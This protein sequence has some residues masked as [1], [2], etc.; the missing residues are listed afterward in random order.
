M[1]FT[2]KIDRA[3]QWAGEKMGAETKTSQSD[4]FQMLEG[5]M[6]FRQTGM[7]SLQKSAAIYVKWAARR[8]DASE[9]KGRST[10]MALL[11]R[12]MTAHSNDF[13]P[14]SEFGNC[15]AHVGRTNERVADF[16]SSYVEDVTA[17]WLQHLERSVTM[18]K[19]YQ[20]ARKKL[21]SRRL[22]YDASLTK[23]QKA[24]RDDFRVEEE[25][26]V[27]KTKYDDSSE[28]V[29]RRMQ[30]IKDA[31]G[32]N[33]GAL[34][35]L[36]DA[37]LA[38]HE[39]AVDE[40]RRARQTL[41]DVSP[42]GSTPQD[43]LCVPRARPSAARSCQPSLQQAR[44]PDYEDMPMPE[45]VTSRRLA[46]AQALPPPPSLQ[47]RPSMMRAS[48]YG[49]RSASAAVTAR[50]PAAR[51]TMDMAYG[52]RED[53]YSDESAGSD[54]A[55][56]DWGTRSISSATSHDSLARVSSVP[57]AKKARPPP[58]VNRAKKPPPP[59]V[60]ARRANLGY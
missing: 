25:M 55:S 6:G 41:A 32:E 36:L 56:P 15:L 29:L 20:A 27:C 12:S 28:D 60:P 52:S 3:R 23:M 47:A 30:D 22:A 11:G 39:R 13:E 5:E 31:E 53:A 35:S 7:E 19:E 50:A 16:H 44:S 51:N 33:V 42:L 8:C 24:K 10:P 48:T 37:E 14:G 18:M 26:R 49:A 46:G 21:E 34:S 43:E 59:L 1:T 45:R 54:G 40:L 17:T 9:D 57:A 2:K 4:E 58:P 38:Y